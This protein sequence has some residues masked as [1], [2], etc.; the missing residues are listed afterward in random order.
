MSLSRVLAV[1]WI[2]PGSS[3][4]TILVVLTLWVFQNIA[5]I[6]KV[7]RGTLFHLI[8]TSLLLTIISFFITGQTMTFY[9]L[10]E[11]RL[12]PT[13]FIVFF[14]GYQPE[15]IQASMYLL[16]YTVLSSLPLLLLFISSPSWLAYFRAG[17]GFWLCLVLTIR[18]IVKTPI[19]LVHVWLP[20]AHVEAPVAGSMVL[21]GILL[22]LGSYGLIMFC[23]LVKSKALL[24]Y[25][26]LSILGS[27]FCRMTCVRQ[28]DLK[29]MIA[30]SSVVHIGVVTVGVVR[31]L[32]LGYV[33]RIIMVVAHGVCSPTMFALA[34]L[35]YKSSHTRTISR[36]KGTLATPTVSFFFFLTLAINIGVP[37]SLNLWRE[38]TIFIS[39]LSVITYSWVFLVA[40]A[41]LGAVYNL[42]LHV[43]LSQSKE[44]DSLK[45]DYVYWPMI[46][47]S[48]LSFSIFFMVGWFYV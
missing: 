22:K 3:L 38:V 45:V 31:G 17:S 18:F 10:F 6:N 25:L 26:S 2:G 42:F 21:A 40:I 36:N 7:T 30:Y 29:S 8:F 46:S 48:Y 16:I 28:W 47:S 12:V 9:I 15:K 19:Y 24:V 39:I 35:V 20:K 43:S 41:F 32:E 34:Y 33:C 4:K 11:L 1:F 14:F 44:S 13:L 37:P 27:L 23:P 5:I